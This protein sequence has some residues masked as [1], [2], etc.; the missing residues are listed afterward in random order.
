VIDWFSKKQRFI[1]LSNTEYEYMA[2]IKAITKANW[3]CHL[4]NN[5]GYP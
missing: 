1:A 4:I 5:I 3:L 2:L